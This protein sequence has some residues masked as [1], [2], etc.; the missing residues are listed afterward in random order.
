ML[1]KVEAMIKEKEELFEKISEYAQKK[2]EEHA[3]EMAE[4]EA[5]ILLKSSSFS[6]IIASI[7]SNIKLSSPL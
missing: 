5:E 7:L 6:L 1:A 4:L 3:K 2:Q